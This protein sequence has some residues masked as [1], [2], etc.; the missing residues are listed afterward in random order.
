MTDLEK[1]LAKIEEGT[2]EL[3]EF[4]K[5]AAHDIEQIVKQVRDDELDSARERAA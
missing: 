3:R 1:A 5:L 2:G 4:D